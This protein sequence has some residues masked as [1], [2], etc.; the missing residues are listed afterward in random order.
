MLKKNRYLQ[1]LKRLEKNYSLNNNFKIFYNKLGLPELFDV[2]LRDG[3]QGLSK[4][5]QNEFTIEKKKELYN[6]ICI[7]HNPKKIEIGSIVSKNVLPIFEDTME[8][9]NYIKEYKDSCNKEKD[10][11]PE[12]FILIPNY[13]K[14]QEVINNTSINNFSFI[15]SV[16]NSFQLKN[17]K[18]TLKESD[19]DL[20]K[21]LYQLEENKYRVLKPNIKLY[22]SCISECPIEGKIDNDFIVS[23]ILLLNKMNVENICLSDTCGSLEIEDFEYIIETCCF[24][25]LLPSKISLHLHVKPGR[26]NIIEKIIHKALDYKII[27]FDVSLIETGGC[28]VTIKK[29]NLAPNLSYDLYY[30]AL[31]NYILKNI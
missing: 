6:N 24:F 20:Y 17:T 18:M 13:T 14:L 11:H 15:T 10:K 8:L 31:C 3:L 7:I 21:M 22:V 23:R 16:S 28:S 12:C 29:E 26:E 30:K 5:Q 4:E 25:G 1:S 27:N 19:Q 9:F 2:T